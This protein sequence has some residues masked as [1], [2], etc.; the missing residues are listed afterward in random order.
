MTSIGDLLV[1]FRDRPSDASAEVLTLTEKNGFVRQA[2][3]FKK[4]LALEDV[5]DYKLIRRNDIAFNPY[6]LW[7]GAV[8]Q[9]TIADSGVIS[10][11]Y[12]TFK[13]RDGF[14]PNFVG[15][16]LLTPDVVSRYDSIAFGSIPRRRRS[17]VSDFLSLTIPT[18]PSIA[19]QRR[20]TAI[21]DQAEQLRARHSRSQ[22][23][24]QSIPQLVFKDCFGDVSVNDAYSVPL[25]EVITSISSGKS[26]KCEARPRDEAANEPG[27][28]KLSAITKG[29]YKSSENKAYPAGELSTAGEVQPGDLLMCRKNTKDLVGTAALVQETPPNLFLP[30]LIY[31]IKYD[32]SR[33]TGEYLLNAFRT[34]GVR[35]K[36]EAAA[37]GSSAS[38]AN[39]SRARL[40]SIHI[41]VPPLKDQAEFSS[42]LRA[43]RKQERRAAKQI[44][45]IDALLNSLQTRAFRGEL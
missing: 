30:D 20:I 26:P 12:P 23:L 22:E 15:R 10:P 14:D 13:V 18:P 43:V 31:R 38:M 44:E 4:R 45:I 6:L 16:L 42:Q 21:L 32:E 36:L 2:D 33:V 1:E 7:A 29:I 11:L 41:H 27:V 17:A 9:N 3:R 28:L 39:I 8:A 34:P 24:I 35:R 25:R 5:S 19:E 40:L 37:S